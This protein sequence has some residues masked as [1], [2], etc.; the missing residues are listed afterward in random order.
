M[1]RSFIRRVLRSAVFKIR[2]YGARQPPASTMMI[3]G[4]MRYSRQGPRT[5]L[6]PL[7]ALLTWKAMLGN[8][9]IDSSKEARLDREMV[10]ALPQRTKRVLEPR[11]NFA[12]P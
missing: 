6:A 10:K 5:A 2:P 4:T 1:K 12:V 8:R 7:S 3:F 11:A 9:G